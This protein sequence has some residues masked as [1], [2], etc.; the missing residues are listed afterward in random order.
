MSLQ[1]KM[2]SWEKKENS[3]AYR[4]GVVVMGGGFHPSLSPYFLQPK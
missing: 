2:K 1:F 3:W 4:V